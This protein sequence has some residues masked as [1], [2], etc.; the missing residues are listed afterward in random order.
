MYST[1]VILLWLLCLYAEDGE[2]RDQGKSDELFGHSIRKAINSETGLEK[3]AA[4]LA[5]QKTAAYPPLERPECQQCYESVF[6][7]SWKP[8]P[9]TETLDRTTAFESQDR[10]LRADDGGD[11]GD[12]G[13]VEP[14]HESQTSS[15]NAHVELRSISVLAHNSKGPASVGVRHPAR[16]VKIRSKVPI[17]D[18]ILDALSRNSLIKED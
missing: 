7:S 9:V 12:V 16:V 1:R 3:N 8:P 18:K 10:G 14:I 2:C 4:R 5:G 17:S 6:L 11:R 15:L 13:P